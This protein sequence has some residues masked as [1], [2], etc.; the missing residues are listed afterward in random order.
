MEYFLNDGELA[1]ALGE[2]PWKPYW[3]LI[4]LSQ[5]EVPPDENQNLTSN[6]SNKFTWPGGVLPHLAVDADDIH[7]ASHIS[8]CSETRPW[9]WCGMPSPPGSSTTWARAATWTCV[10][11]QRTRWTTSVPMRR[12]TRREWGQFRAWGWGGRC[13]GGRGGGGCEE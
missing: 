1:G 11:S 7:L 12:P 3:K 4:P 2:S 8:V 10:S 13:G 5:M 9:S 6:V